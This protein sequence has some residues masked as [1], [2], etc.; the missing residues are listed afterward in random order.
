MT[1]IDKKDLLSKKKSELT[2]EELKA[3]TTIIGGPGRPYPVMATQTV[4]GEDN[5][6]I[7]TKVL[8][9]YEDA[10]NPLSVL[11]ER[12]F[13]EVYGIALRDMPSPSMLGIFSKV[14]NSRR[15]NSERPVTFIKGDPG[16]GKSFM[17]KMLGKMKSKKGA[18][19][20]DCGGKNLAELM[21]ETVLDMNKDSSFYND[22]DQ[23]LADGLI[24]PASL[25]SLENAVKST[26]SE[27]V[28]VKEDNKIIAV[29]WEKF[30]ANDETRKVLEWVGVSEGLIGN[31]NALGMITQ[32]G[33][34]IQAWKEG[35]EIVLDEYNKSKENTDDSLQTVWQFL[36][37]EIDYEEY[38]NP[39]KEKGSVSGQ[40]FIFRREDQ[41]AGFGIT[42]TGN[43]V[44]D[45]ISTRPLSKSLYSRITPMNLKKAEETDWQHRWCQIL[46]GMPVSTLYDLA[47]DQ[48]DENPEAFTKFLKEARLLGLSEEQKKNVP[49]H[50]MDM[51][52][53]WQ[54]VLQATEGLARFCHGWEQL[55]DPF[56]EKLQSPDFSD[57]AM[58]IDEEYHAETSIDFRKITDFVQEAVLMNPQPTAL[59]QSGGFDLTFGLDQMVE[60]DAGT[61]QDDPMIRF[62]SRLVRDMMGMV[63]ATSD[64]VG[65]P[66]LYAHLVELAEACGLK[67]VNLQEANAEPRKTIAELLNI[68]PFTSQDHSTQVLV[69]QGLIAERI[70]QIDPEIQADKDQIIPAAHVRRAL[71]ELEEKGLASH[72][73]VLTNTDPEYVEASPFAYAGRIDPIG[74]TQEEALFDIDP[75]ELVRKDD[76]LTALMLPQLD[77]QNVSALWGET[78]SEH[79]PVT[80]K[81]HPAVEMAEG[82]HESGVAVTT[83]KVASNDQE[84]SE[85]YHLLKNE[86]TDDLILIGSEVPDFVAK[87]YKKRGIRV[88]DRS[89]T[90]AHNKIDGAI[91]EMAGHLGED[92]L[93]YLRQAFLHRNLPTEGDEFGGDRSLGELMVAED[94]QAFLPSFLVTRPEEEVG[95]SDL[96]RPSRPLK[97]GPK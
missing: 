73:F 18:I 12:D 71:D 86:K 3:L 40:K 72:D 85:V 52:S 67:K 35:R 74:A 7:H 63:S 90:Q 45:G 15:V 2:K 79:G 36:V 31:E 87:E 37:G 10:E 33:P 22:F 13:A 94:V 64:D 28:F 93:E 62:G 41:K 58:E 20:V 6:E 92:G 27:D 53:N 80:S 81:S 84:G 39:L 97:M 51:L 24:N 23:K 47:S 48:W 49:Q 88:I 11:S 54:N 57:V 82:R 56:S 46:T 1:K 21:Y 29:N 61:E 89:D 95:K 44:E 42:I 55:T 25:S 17:G 66:N 8:S 16:A 43:A 78:L 77:Q 76:F 30:P 70:R 32:E 83:V 19:V 75:K 59:A 65:K 38:E 5:Q 9:A 91:Q 69:L 60:H 4:R 68:N 50:Q 96:R 34:L 14:L 26:D